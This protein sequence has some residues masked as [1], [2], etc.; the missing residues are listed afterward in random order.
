LIA[1]ADAAFMIEFRKMTGACVAPV[2]CPVMSPW[3]D[4]NLK[5]A[6]M[7]SRADVD[8]LL[9][10]SALRTATAQ[11]LHGADARDPLAS[12]PYGDLAGRPPVQINVGD[13]EVLLD[14]ARQYVE[15]AVRAGVDVALHVWEGM[16][17]VLESNVGKLAASD[18][19]LALIGA[20]LNEH[21][22]KA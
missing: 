15:R 4:L 10:E 21:F 6:S 20:F 8:P 16:P 14:D 7:K 17:H 19:A 1:P 11:Y 2:A 9:T 3:T 22:A 12:P 5:G 13:A 18:E